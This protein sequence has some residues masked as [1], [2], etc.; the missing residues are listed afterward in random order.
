MMVC[1]WRGMC[2]EEGG[3]ETCQT[4]ER[5]N[6]LFFFKQW[7]GGEELT[8]VR[9]QTSDRRRKPGMFYAARDEL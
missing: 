3:P 8:A 2:E 4:A 1:Q 6:C 7:G 5:L 9:A